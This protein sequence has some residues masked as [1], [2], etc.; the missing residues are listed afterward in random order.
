VSKVG[1]G[2][3]FENPWETKNLKAWS[4]HVAQGKSWQEKKSVTAEKLLALGSGVSQMSVLE[5]PVAAA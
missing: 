3:Q 1:K 2:S 4:V 5:G